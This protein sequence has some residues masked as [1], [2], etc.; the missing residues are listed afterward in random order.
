[1]IN[2]DKRVL[3]VMMEWDYGIRERGISI[4]KHCFYNNIKTMVSHVEPFWI[5]DYLNNTKQLQID[6][7]NKAKEFQPDLIFFMPYTNQF[8]IET[9]T[10]LK[11]NYTT[12]AWFGDDQ[13]RFDSYSS[14]YAPYYT[15][16][17]TTDPWSVYK[18]KKIGVEPILSEWAA[19]PT[20][21]PLASVEHHGKYEYDVTFIGGANYVRKWFI[22]QLLKR[23][24]NVECFGSG[25][26]NGRVSYQQMEHIFSKSKIN[27]NLSKL[28]VQLNPFFW[29]N[30]IFQ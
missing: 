13:W 26:S 5:D 25:W 29:H 28:F 6:L 9:L 12:Y 22:S 23:G 20:E 30:T 19:Q 17:S 7:L 10:E 1:M 11:K 2:W 8:S 18:Y 24:I 21:S 15:Y 14:K 16:I 3:A 27:L 4:E